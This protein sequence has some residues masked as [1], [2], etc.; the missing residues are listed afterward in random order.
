V[1]PKLIRCLGRAD[2]AE[3]MRRWRKSPRTHAVR[4]LGADASEEQWLQARLAGIGASE[5]ASV[6]DVPGAYRS[7]YALWWAKVEGWTE[8]DSFEMKVGRKLEP[9]I[10]ELFA[11]ERPDLLVCRPNGRLWR[12]PV[13]E[14][15]LATPDFLAAT[16]AGTVEP[17]ECKS[18][19]GG[20][21]WGQPGT[22]Q[23]PYRHAVQI[24]QQMLVMGAVRGHLVRLAGKRMA[25]Y[26]LNLDTELG[27]AEVPESWVK[28]AEAFLASLELGTPPDPD[29]S[30]STLDTLLR[31]YPAV[32]P[33]DDDGNEPLAFLDDALLD[34]LAAAK[35]A[36]GEAEARFK[37]ADHMVRDQM[38]AAKYACR[39]TTGA[40]V[41]T[42]VQYKRAGYEV[43]PST[44]DQLRVKRSALTAQTQAY[45]GGTVPP[46]GI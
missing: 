34:E 18:D 45:A 15:M 17:V 37:T 23:V 43:A 27:T 39:R 36:L 16:E 4:L 9:V 24:V 33:P 13:H 19:E 28:A 26:T 46:Q 29:A 11:E 3:A 38:G 10:G 14:W 6:L 35:V 2:E 5:M 25:R 8:A 12:H 41:A 7:R 32:D 20:H 1:K 21:G 44:V 30:D 40:V 42:R 31:L 22:D